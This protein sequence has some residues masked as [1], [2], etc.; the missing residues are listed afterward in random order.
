MLRCSLADQPALA[1]LRGLVGTIA[2]LTDLGGAV[3]VDPQTLS[4]FEAAEWRRR[5]FADDVFSARD[6]VLILCDDDERNAGRVYVHTRGLRKFARPDLAIRNVP[7]AAASAA[8]EL[9]ARFVDFEAAGGLVGDGH[10]VDIDGAPRGMVVRAAGA[11]DD[12]E[13]NNRHLA[14]HWPEPA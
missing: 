10:Q 13:F 4:M 12:P 9:A 1:Y 3:V 7:P 6:H 2:A 14:L 8:G 5:F 11:L